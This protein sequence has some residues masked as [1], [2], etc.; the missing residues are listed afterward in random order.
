[1]ALSLK[2]KVGSKIYI[3]KRPLHVTN[4]KADGT[5][6]V[7]TDKGLLIHLS[8]L[9]SAEVYPGVFICIGTMVQPGTASLCI[10]APPDVQ[11]MRE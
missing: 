9:E 3:G 11:I 6:T 7:E 8:D 2:V 10:Q 5:A 4:A 1:V